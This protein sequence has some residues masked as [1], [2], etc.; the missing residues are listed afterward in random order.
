[1]PPA[2]QQVPAK[3]RLVVLA[4]ALRARVAA[5]PSAAKVVAFFSNC[6]A[7][8]F[9]HAGMMLSKGLHVV[10]WVHGGGG[11]RW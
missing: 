6:D 4:A 10:L 2:H 7:V 3:L 9:F 5:A 8:E 1:M 11:L